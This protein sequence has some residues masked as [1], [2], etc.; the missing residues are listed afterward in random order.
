MKKLKRQFIELK[1]YM[2]IRQI[3][4]HGILPLRYIYF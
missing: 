2:W 3:C 1:G 4:V